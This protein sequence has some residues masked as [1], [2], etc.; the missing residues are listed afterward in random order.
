MWWHATAQVPLQW[1]TEYMWRGVLHQTGLDNRRKT[2][3]VFWKALCELIILVLA[4]VLD[5][6]MQDREGQTARISP[7]GR[8][9]TVIFGG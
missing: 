8:L 1:L 9:C 4:N 7:Q 2:T 3:P 6:A 5:R